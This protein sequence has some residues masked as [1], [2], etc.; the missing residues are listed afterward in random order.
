M[1][2]L[3]ALSGLFSGEHMEVSAVTVASPNLSRLVDVVE[4]L[5]KEERAKY[6]ASFLEEPSWVEGGV[7]MRGKVSDDPGL[8]ALRIK[9]WPRVKIA[10]Q[11]GLPTCSHCHSTDIRRDPDDNRLWGCAECGV[12]SYSVF[13]YFGALTCPEDGVILATATQLSGGVSCPLC[14]ATLKEAVA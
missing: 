12:E 13:I 8:I 5:P 14:K 6:F 11:K 7:I 1:G 9:D 2:T 10:S 3:R 4:A